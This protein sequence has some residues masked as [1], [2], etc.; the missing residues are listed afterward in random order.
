MVIDGDRD[1]DVTADRD[2]DV[3]AIVAEAA[4]ASSSDVAESI[5]AAI[6]ANDERSDP[7]PAVGRLLEVA[8]TQAQQ[9]VAR[10]GWLRNWLRLLRR[11]N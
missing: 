10:V 3:T 11:G 7:D 9:S 8:S 2:H 4:V 1:H 5:Q 6:E